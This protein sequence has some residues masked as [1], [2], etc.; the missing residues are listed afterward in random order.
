M[1]TNIGSSNSI[2]DQPIK[3]MD[4]TWKFNDKNIL[5]KTE[6]D[7][8]TRNKKKESAKARVKIIEGEEQK[9]REMI[10]LKHLGYKL[11][12]KI[13]FSPNDFKPFIHNVVKWPN[14]L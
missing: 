9:F 5:Q 1:S 11:S 13:R 4:K 6:K 14:I 7:S 10:K 12:E 2:K 8:R 3:D